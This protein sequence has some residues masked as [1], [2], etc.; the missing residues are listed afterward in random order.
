MS[1]S[2][3]ANDESDRLVA[4]WNTMDDA[5]STPEPD[6]SQIE[7]ATPDD[8]VVLRRTDPTA[9]LRWRRQVRR[10]LGDRIAAGAKVTGFTRAGTYLLQIPS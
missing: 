1:D 3:N 5:P 4:A 8:I 10:D 9:A 6:G 7:V 2:I